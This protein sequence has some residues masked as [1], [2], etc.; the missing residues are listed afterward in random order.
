MQLYTTG[1]FIL[2]TSGKQATD[3]HFTPRFLQQIVPCLPKRH[4]PVSAAVVVNTL[5]TGRI[6]LRSHRPKKRGRI[7]P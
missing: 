7:T 5:M 6:T 2:G 3:G 4:L 1:G